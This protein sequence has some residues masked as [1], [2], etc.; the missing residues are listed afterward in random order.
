MVEVAAPCR[1]AIKEIEGILEKRGKWILDKLEAASAE[2]P[3]SHL[4][5]GESIPLMGK[6]LTLVVK[7]TDIRRVS[8]TSD[9]ERLEVLVPQELPSDEQQERVRTAVVRWYRVQIEEYL[10][11]RVAHWLPQMGREQMPKIL[12]REQ[13][14]RWGSCSSDS[15]LRF[16]WRLAMVEPEL[17][18]S[19]VV[20][21]L[22]HLDVMNHSPAFWQ[23]VLRAMPDA[24][25]RRKRLNYAGRR[26]PL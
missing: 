3:P 13:R 19:V 9:G 4:V 11:Q 23:V 26:L 24:R 5:T 7:P 21:E 20:H 14:A 16:S 2:P 17:I 1:T 12:V 10:R 25:E 22:A 18:D 6:E 15:T 8:V